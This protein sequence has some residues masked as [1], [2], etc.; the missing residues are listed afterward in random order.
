MDRYRA[1]L[2]TRVDLSE[3]DPND[4]SAFPV[5]K[6]EGRKL[7]LELNQRLETLQELLYAEHKHKVLIVLQGMDHRE[8]ELLAF[9][10]GLGQTKS[11]VVLVDRRRQ[12]VEQ[13]FAV[14]NRLIRVAVANPPVDIGRCPLI[15]D[16][17]NTDV[18]PAKT[19]AIRTTQTTD[20]RC[21]RG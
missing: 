17:E 9:S 7:L 19:G 16:L 18:L 1:Q 13:H 15:A 4:K 6:K 5:K 12:N 3:W 2:G 8:V 21:R 20:T 11:Q 10:D 14:R